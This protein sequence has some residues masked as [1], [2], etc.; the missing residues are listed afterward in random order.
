MVRDLGVALRIAVASYF[1]AR[2]IDITDSLTRPFGRG[3]PK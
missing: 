2:K 3:A 1:E